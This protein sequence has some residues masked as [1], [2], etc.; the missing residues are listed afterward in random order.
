MCFVLRRSSVWYCN[1]LLSRPVFFLQSSQGVYWLAY[2]TVSY[3]V[4]S[5]HIMP[6]HIISCHIISYHVMSYVMSYVMSCHVMSCHTDGVA[7]RNIGTV[8][9]VLLCYPDTSMAFSAYVYRVLLLLFAIVHLP[10]EVCFI[11][12]KNVTNVHPLAVQSLLYG[13]GLYLC[14]TSRPLR[15]CKEPQTGV[16]PPRRSP[17][18]ILETYFRGS[19]CVAVWK[20]EARVAML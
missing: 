16:S 9:L 12:T 2:Y 11:C 19:E 14:S 5:Y 6:C 7:A 18:C 1:E 17:P 13:L 10:P 20:L 3:H 15:A 8:P 4:I